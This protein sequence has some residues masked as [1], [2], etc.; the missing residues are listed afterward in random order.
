MSQ[1]VRSVA[2]L[3]IGQLVKI[4]TPD[5]EIRGL[6]LSLLYSTSD[7]RDKYDIKK[8]RGVLFKVD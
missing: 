2:N 8:R 4:C 5:Q 1:L 7:C 6:N 3:R